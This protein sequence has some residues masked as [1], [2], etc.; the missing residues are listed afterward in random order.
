M[1][2]LLKVPKMSWTDGRMDEQGQSKYALLHFSNLGYKKKMHSTAI[3][4]D[5]NYVP[6][7]V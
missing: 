6:G 5:Q 1:F 2:F 3:L 4:V 7:G